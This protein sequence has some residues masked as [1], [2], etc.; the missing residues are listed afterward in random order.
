MT[1]QGKKNLLRGSSANTENWF[2]HKCDSS[3]VHKL[4]T[5]GYTSSKRRKSFLH[6]QTKATHWPATVK[7]C[8][9]PLDPVQS[10]EA[11]RF[12][13]FAGGMASDKHDPLA[14]GTNKPQCRNEKFK[15][16]P[17]GRPTNFA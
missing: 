16:C 11:T 8:A 12:C 1:A 15:D 17:P 7:Q 3:Y 10:K 13:R 4:D 2:R 14:I 5:H 6:L 9:M